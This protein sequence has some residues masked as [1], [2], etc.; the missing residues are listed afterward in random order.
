MAEGYQLYLVR[1]AVA[2]QRGD[3]YPDDTK[4]PLTSRGISKLKREVRGLVALDVAFDVVLTSPLTRARQ[5]ADVLA[6]ALSSKPSVVNCASLAPGGKY[7]AVVE[8]LSRHARKPRIALVGHE[9]DI[10]QLA[11]R[12]IGAR[13]AIAFKKGAICRIDIEALPP[14]APGALRWFITPR[15]LRKC[16]GK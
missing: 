10:G 9:P 5:T 14:A 15:M 12:L 6:G 2:A 11:A 13:G 7:A 16:S 8:D 4:R 1:H 3:D